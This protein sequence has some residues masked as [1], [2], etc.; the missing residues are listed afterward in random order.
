MEERSIIFHNKPIAVL[1]GGT[2]S[3]KLL[4]ARQASTEGGGTLSTATHTAE[5]S[6]MQAMEDAQRLAAHYERER[7]AAENAA[8][9]QKNT[10]S[11]TNEPEEADYFQLGLDADDEDASK[12]EQRTNNFAL[13]DE[14]NYM[15]PFSDSPAAS[16]GYYLGRRL[17]EVVGSG[18]E[19]PS[20]AEEVPVKPTS[21][22][23]DPTLRDLTIN[24]Y[25][26]G[27]NN[28]ALGQ[29]AWKAM[30]GQEN[31]M[32]KYAEEL[33]SDDYNFKTDS[34]WK[35]AVSGAAQQLGQWGRQMNDPDTL[36]LATGMGG[37]ALL[38]GWAGPQALVPEE[39]V[40]VPGAFVAGMTA[41]NAKTNMEIEGGLAYLE[42]LENG[43]SEETARAIATGVGVV[44]AGLEALQLDELVKAYRVLDKIGADN[45]LLKI[46]FKELTR[47]GV[48]VATESAQENAQ[49]LVTIG[50]V[51]LGSRLDTGKWA[52]TA[53][54]VGER[55][56]DTTKNSLLTFA[57]T[58]APAA[59]HNIHVHMRAKIASDGYTKLYAGIMPSDAELRA[60]GISESEALGALAVFEMG[61]T[62]ESSDATID[63]GA[64]LDVATA[65]PTFANSKDQLYQNSKNIK[66]INGYEDVVVHGDMY[67][68]VFKNADGEE[69][70][71]SVREFAHILKLLGT[72][73]SLFPSILSFFEWDHL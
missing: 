63:T 20:A 15:N 24:S 8:N 73:D 33:R 29:E 43:V 41:G 58:N 53:D 32:D 35:N 9:A 54:E 23:R 52:Y 61:K 45:T 47:R 39:I 65:S 26:Y 22:S 31:E 57:L 40:T 21:E 10:P 4:K 49:E 7:K 70:T 66:R 44:N 30:Y 11:T 36:T 19:P 50:G 48:D 6:N 37:A 67:G 46:V 16:L 38:A 60:M 56:W 34:W 55:L 5:P 51:Q 14:Y 12:P 27:Y 62:E 3:G 2:G 69:S 28:A 13:W 1:D 18:T 25:K 17:S 64:N 68:F 72:D 42:M 71:V 59:G